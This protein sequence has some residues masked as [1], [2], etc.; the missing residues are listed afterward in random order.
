MS[1]GVLDNSWIMS[2]CP[3]VSRTILGSCNNVQ[4]CHG[5]FR[6]HPYVSLS[7]L[8]KGLAKTKSR[9][10]RPGLSQELGDPRIVPGHHILDIAPK[11]A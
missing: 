7:L 8:N 2:K 3:V 4:W 6:D 9:L 11:T 10:A 1:S 5:Q